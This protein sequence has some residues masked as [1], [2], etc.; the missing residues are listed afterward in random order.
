MKKKEK[1]ER[2]NGN[3]KERTKHAVNW[4]KMLTKSKDGCRKVNVRV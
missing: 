3:E 2:R 4:S 1:W